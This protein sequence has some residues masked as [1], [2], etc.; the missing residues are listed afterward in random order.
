[1]LNDPSGSDA[2]AGNKAETEK[3]PH[4][5]FINNTFSDQLLEAPKGKERNN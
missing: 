5:L 1:M 4:N 3:A 2:E